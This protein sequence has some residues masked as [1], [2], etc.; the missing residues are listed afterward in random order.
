MR[1]L[2]NLVVCVCVTV[3]RMY[4]RVC[5]H[6]EFFLSWVV[7]VL[8]CVFGISLSAASCPVGGLLHV[9]PLPPY[10]W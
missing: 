9:H 4:V 2:R 8:N 10:G 1:A 3:Y 5:M 6:E 7:F